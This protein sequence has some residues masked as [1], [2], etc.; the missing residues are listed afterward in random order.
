M[1]RVFRWRALRGQ[2]LGLDHDPQLFYVGAMFRDV[3]LVDGHRSTDARFE[4]YGANAARVFLERHGLPEEQVMTVWE[5]IALHTTPGIPRYKQ[6]E[7][8]MVNLGAEYDVAGRG[9]DELTEDQRQAVLDVYPRTGFKSGIIELFSEGMRDKPETA[10]G[11]MNAD[12]LEATVPG[13]VRPNY[14]DLIRDAPFP[15]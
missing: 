4:V 12:I 10:Y 11:T 13:Y 1:H 2:R 6:G 7:V 14:C 3:G 5:S 15:A 8:R 9:F